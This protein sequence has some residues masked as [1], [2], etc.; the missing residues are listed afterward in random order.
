M[1]KA[2]NCTFNIQEKIYRFDF[3]RPVFCAC[4]KWNNVDI[5]EYLV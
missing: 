5:T 4:G 1:L 3:L 2:R